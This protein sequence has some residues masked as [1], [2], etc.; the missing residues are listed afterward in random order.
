MFH[1]LSARYDGSLLTIGRNGE[2]VGSAQFTTLGPW[3]L[4]QVGG[5][6]SSDF[7]IG[8]LAEVLVYDRAL[9]SAD[10]KLTQAYLARKYGL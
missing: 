10:T 5:W 9:S 4:G 8:D 6:F 7:L 3:A 2:E 1:E